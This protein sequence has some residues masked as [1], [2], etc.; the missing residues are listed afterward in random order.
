LFLRDVTELPATVQGRL[1]RLARDGEM[2]LEGQA[3]AANFKLVASAPP[4]IERDVR[5][6]RFRP[7]LYRRLAA[8][9]IDLPPRR[10][11]LQ[12]LRHS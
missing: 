8:S 4:S 9:R 2:L 3:V 10:D 12:D 6:H 11:R 5:E 1:A 7:D